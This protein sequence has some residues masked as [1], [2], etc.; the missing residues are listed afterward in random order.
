MTNSKG[1]QLIPQLLPLDDGSIRVKL[2]KVD[3]MQWWEV[4]ENCTGVFHDKVLSR[5][6]YADCKANWIL[7]T[8]NDMLFPSSLSPFIGGGYEIQFDKI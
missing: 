2:H 3:G 5:L 1:L 7:Y 6:P 8:F 4:S